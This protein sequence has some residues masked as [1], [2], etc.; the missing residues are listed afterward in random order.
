MPL[1]FSAPMIHEFEWK[2]DEWDRLASG[3]VRGTR[4]RVWAHREVAVIVR[5]NWETIPA[6]ADVGYPHSGSG[7]R[8]KHSS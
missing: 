8:R 6:L 2:P 7:G 1:W 5:T 3:I 4:H